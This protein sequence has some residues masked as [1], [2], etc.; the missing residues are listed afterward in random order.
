M[1][2]SNAVHSSD[3][4][5]VAL[6]LP[7]NYGWGMRSPSDRNWYWQSG[8]RAQQMWSFALSLL[9]KYGSNL[10]IIYDDLAVIATNKYERI[11][12]WCFFVKT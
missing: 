8:E 6:I 3:E 5:D 4:V 9:S 1:L 12:Y 10:D 7:I 2:N 11:Y